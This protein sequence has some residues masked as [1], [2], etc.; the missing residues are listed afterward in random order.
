MEV[1]LLEKVR[2][3]GNLGDKVNV[4][5]GYGRNFLI[6]QNKAVFATPKN[7]E[8]FE[9]RRVE[10][11]KKAQQSFAVAEQRAA[12]L[13]DTT[14]VINAMASD[15]GKLYGSVGVNEIKDALV[16]KGIEIVKREI[17]MPEGPLHSIGNFVVEVHVHSDVIA[18][19][20]VEI[21]PAK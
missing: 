16:D 21:V 13:N 17:V 6:P 2:N 9:Q 10:L 14:I 5:S 4:K 7:I 11:E 1:I 20:H 3:L 19:L 8:L 12:K 15:E 18:K